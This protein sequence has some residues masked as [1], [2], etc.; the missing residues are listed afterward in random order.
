M[1]IGDAA[2]AVGL[3]PRALRYYEER[4]LFTARRSR[5]G[6]REYGAEDL[7]RLRA[8]RELLDAGLTIRDVESL[9]PVLDGRPPEV[10]PATGDG[11]AGGCPVEN[12]TLR[13]LDGLDQAIE[14][15]TAL[16]GRLAHALD[17]RFGDGFRTAV[18]RQPRETPVDRA[19]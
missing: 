7:D 18:A 4:G 8:M 15:L 12:V 16:R 9:V 10:G 17:H 6:H 11:G 2:A 5:V 1:R 19:A 14:R 3:T 13:R